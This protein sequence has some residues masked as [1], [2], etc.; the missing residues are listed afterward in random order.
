MEGHQISQ[1]WLPLS[2]TCLFSMCFSCIFSGVEIHIDLSTLSLKNVFFYAGFAFELSNVSHQQ[3]HP[4]LKAWKS[5]GCSKFIPFQ[6]NPVSSLQNTF[7]L[8]NYSNVTLLWRLVWTDTIFGRLGCS[9]SRKLMKSRGKKV[10][11]VP[12][13]G[14][15][16]LPIDCHPLLTDV[17]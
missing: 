15:S 3:I 2:E 11:F 12:V 9:T 1:S 16:V 10:D 8:L 5:P 6:T 17:L 7:I 4:H 13:L 14:I